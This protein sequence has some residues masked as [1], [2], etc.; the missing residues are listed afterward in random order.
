MEGDDSFS[1]C[2]CTPA[3]DVQ[4]E[5]ESNTTPIAALA[6]A[7]AAAH[8]VETGGLPPLYEAID[9]DLVDEF[10]HHGRRRPTEAVL[11]FQIDTWVVF[12][13]VD[14]KIRVCDGT[15]LTDP[16]PVF[17]EFGSY[18]APSRSPRDRE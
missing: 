3:V 12:V 16:T 2:R 18:P 15:R 1:Y 5:T 10:V 7:L 8:G 11:S 13:S 14:G 4:Y 9:P 17:E 6:D